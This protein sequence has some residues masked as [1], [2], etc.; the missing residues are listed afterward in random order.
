[1]RKSNVSNIEVRKTEHGWSIGFHHPDPAKRYIPPSKEETRRLVE[2]AEREAGETP[3]ED[4][5]FRRIF[6]GWH[7]A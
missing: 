5:F 2:E 7:G 3:K 4:T 1:M 6:E